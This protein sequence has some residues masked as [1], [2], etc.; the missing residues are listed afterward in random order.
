MPRSIKKGPFVDH[1]LAKKVEEARAKND[2]Y[3][4]GTGASGCTSFMME[5]TPAGALVW[6]NRYFGFGAVDGS[7]RENAG[8]RLVTVGVCRDPDS[9]IA[10]TEALLMSTSGAG[11]PLFTQAYGGDRDEAGDAVDLSTDGFVVGAHTDSFAFGGEDFYVLKTDAAGKTG[12]ERDRIVD[13]QPLQPEIVQLQLRPEPRQENVT[14]QWDELH[15]N[16]PVEFVCD[17]NPCPTCAAEFAPP[18]GVSD[19][20]DVVAFLGLFAAMDP[21]AD[22]AAP[23]GVWDFSDVVAFLSTFGAPCP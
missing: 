17:P 9:A 14:W 5:L 2:T 12:C 18:F 15:P 10:S 3:D 11:I 19:F 23:A 20:S 8:G 21:C 4:D 6:Y 22:L 13:F 1:H 7:V 16:H